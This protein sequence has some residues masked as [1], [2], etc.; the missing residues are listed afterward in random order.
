MADLPER[1]DWIAVDWSAAQPRAWALAADGQILARADSDTSTAGPAQAFD[2]ALR[3]LIEPWLTTGRKTPVVICGWPGAPCRMV[4]CTPGADAAVTVPTEDPRVTLTLLPGLAQTRPADVMQGA[5]TR[6]AGFL[7]ANPGFDGTLCLPG[8]HTRWV[9]VSAGEIVSFRS[10]MTGDLFAAITGHTALRHLPGNGREDR[11][12]FLDAVDDAM[13]R[14]EALTARL[15]SLHAETL[16]GTPD[17]AATSRVSGLLIGLELAGARGY[18]L[19]TRLALIGH[20]PLADLYDAAL[21]RQGVHVERADA[22][23]AVLAGLKAA[24][25]AIGA[26]DA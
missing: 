22:E 8:R 13:A 4:P 19:G 21:T 17:P 24:R 9:Q 1:P 26:G 7:A 6:A 15:F 2:P 12:S 10:V 16:L 25:A 20:G 5:A 18:W 23:E 3:A 14:P 11:D